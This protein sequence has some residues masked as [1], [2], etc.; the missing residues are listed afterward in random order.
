MKV[1]VD[2]LPKKCY[3]CPCCNIDLDCGECCSLG[4]FDCDDFY[5]KD[6]HKNCPLQTLADNEKQVRKQVCDEIRELAENYFN[7]PICYNCGETSNDD[8][9]LTGNDLTDILEQI[10]KGE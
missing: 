9:I 6:R 1:Y 5:I 2:E 3:D 8:V 4:A 10:E 7:L